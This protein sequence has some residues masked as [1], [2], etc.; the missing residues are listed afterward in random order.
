VPLWQIDVRALG[1]TPWSVREGIETKVGV[2]QICFRSDDQIIVTFV[3]HLIPETLPRRGQPDVSSNLRLHALFVDTKTGH[4]RATREWPTFSERSRIMPAT[5][6]KFVVITPDKLTLYSPEIQPL[7][8]LELPVG[9]EATQNDWTAAP[10]PAGK[11]LLISYG[12]RTNENDPRGWVGAVEKRE[13]IDTETLQVVRAWTEAAIRYFEAALDNGTIFFIGRQG[14]PVI[15]LP[16]GPWRAAFLDWTP[17][18]HPSDYVT[19]SD[20]AVLG[21]R[22]LSLHKWCYSL[23]LTTGELLFTQELAE[24]EMLRLVSPSAGGKRFAMSV[25]KSKGGS[26]LLDIA[27]RWFL[28]RVMVYD[29]PSRRWILALDG[30]R[31]DITSIS[32]LGLSP[33]GSLLGLINEDGILQVYGIPDASNLPQ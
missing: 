13:L 8:E 5:D 16:E 30:K 32:G 1:Y 29:I 11:Y 21:L 31:Q 26:D 28:R 2:G 18:N 15:G 7:K 23:A 4:L 17:K 33:D 19:V 12:P 25:D 22:P 24:G 27:P 9:R 6:G 20:D 14:N 10:S 3:S